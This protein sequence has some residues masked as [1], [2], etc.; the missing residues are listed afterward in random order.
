V[1]SASPEREAAPA[2]APALHR[3]RLQ[4]AEPGPAEP[5]PPERQA[6]RPS[7]GGVAG[8]PSA[9]APRA[10]ET[11]ATPRLEETNA[12]L[13]PP[14]EVEPPRALAAP[15]PKPD[16]TRAL[17]A[18]QHGELDEAIAALPGMLRPRAETPRPERSTAR[19][20]S[21]ERDPR[22]ELSIGRIELELAQPAP[23]VAPPPT[24]VRR[25]FEGYG[26]ARRGR[27]R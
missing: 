10:R 25:G 4:D 23:A 21:P 19:A 8:E 26:A 15:A 12:A 24:G 20:D 22:L 11:D 2:S 1:Q 6:A 5:P 18:A 9:E 3:A 13:P 7:S 14:A 27:V 17:G 16:G